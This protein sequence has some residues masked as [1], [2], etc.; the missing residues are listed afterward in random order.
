MTT[1]Y[2]AAIHDNQNITFR[3]FALNC[4]R[5][6]GPLATLKDS[7]GP[8]PETLP[9]NQYHAEEAAEAEKDLA[10]F[11][12]M[13]PEEVE[14]LCAGA[15]AKACAEWSEVQKQKHWLRMR[16]NHMLDEVRSWVAP[17]KDHL[18]LKLF[19]EQQLVDSI[20]YDCTDYGTAPVRQEYGQQWFEQK[21]RALKEE[22]AYHRKKYEEEVQRTAWRNAW[23]KSLRD[24]LPAA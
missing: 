24:S 14:Q 16:Y 13:S 15:Y 1:A 23:L 5:A 9:V 7:S 21:R 19:M 10:A 22:L 17:S 3:N 12:A 8:I 18:N 4:A 11:Q 6:F 2:T 20:K